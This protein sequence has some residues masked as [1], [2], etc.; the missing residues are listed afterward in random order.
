VSSMRLAANNHR[1]LAQLILSIN[2]KI[3]REIA[4][5]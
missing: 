5:E 1:V 4:V 2:P 3:G